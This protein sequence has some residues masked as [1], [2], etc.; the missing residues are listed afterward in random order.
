[1]SAEV[2]A[3]QGSWRIV[4]PADRLIDAHLALVGRG[5]DRGLTYEDAADL[6]AAYRAAT[7]ALHQCLGATGFM[8]SFAW[9]WRPYGDAVGEPNPVEGYDCAVHVFGRR[10]GEPLSPVRAMAV[11]RPDR[12]P[13][14]P[15]PSLTEQLRQA[16]ARPPAP[17]T[18]V[19][20]SPQPGE[21]CDGCASSVLTDQE[22]WRR[23]GVR[24]IRP[25][26]V[27]LDPHVLLLPLRHVTSLRDLTPDEV[28]SLAVRLDETLEQCRLASGSTGLSG[29][30]NDGIAARQET[31]HVHLHC[32]GRAI[33][34][35][36]NP[37]A[38]LAALLPAPPPRA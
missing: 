6:I 18:I 33:D 27:Q 21:P 9:S 31:P 23:D 34:E 28:V 20:P 10:P 24:V 16:L 12:R 17:L 26:R 15:D 11:P 5:P 25:R 29:F 30:A 2:V 36:V 38:R 7:S 19:G 35:P 37:Y 4:A 8:I 3:D 1:M 32:Y 14:Q 13:V 22:R